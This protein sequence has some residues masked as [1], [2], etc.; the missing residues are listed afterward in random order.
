MLARLILIFNLTFTHTA[1]AN[2]IIEMNVAG[3]Y[4]CRNYEA[5]NVMNLEP[6]QMEIA[7]TDS[8]ERLFTFVGKVVLTTYPATGS[9]PTK[10]RYV[11]QWEYARAPSVYLFRA[12][13][14][15]GLFT[16]DKLTIEE[17]NSAVTP[18]E[19]TTIR[20]INSDGVLWRLYSYECIKR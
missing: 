12:D 5:I 9:S 10:Q 16:W 19:I 1:Y 17:M 4:V 7:A 20:E 6:F 18:Y 15:D 2:S 13:A 8:L 14:A 3:E 11:G